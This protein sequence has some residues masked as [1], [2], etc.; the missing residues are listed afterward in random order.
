MQPHRRTVADIDR[1]GN[2]VVAWLVDQTSLGAPSARI[3]GATVDVD[4]T[5][6]PPAVPA[7][8]LE[9]VLVPDYIDGVPELDG[10]G[11]AYEYRFDETVPSLAHVALIRSRGSDGAFEGTVY[12]PGRTSSLAED[13][14]W[15]DA[16][17]IR[18]PGPTL[19]DLVTR[20]VGNGRDT[21]VIG[22]AILSWITDQAG[23]AP[24]GAAPPAATP[25]TIDLDLFT[26]IAVADVEDLLVP[27]YLPFLPPR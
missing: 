4:V 10:W 20:Q 16:L 15:A 5:D 8:A 25:G 24:P 9:A 19:L 3:G 23:L 11:N 13:L 17:E 22:A 2:A 18:G 14:V 7:L 26:Q 1:V 12:T 21:R 27:R 6:Y